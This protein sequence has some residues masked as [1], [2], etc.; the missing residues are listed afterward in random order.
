MRNMA[1][2]AYHMAHSCESY[3]LRMFA[4]LGGSAHEWPSGRALGTINGL[5]AD[6]REEFPHFTGASVECS[7]RGANQ[8]VVRMERFDLQKGLR[9]RNSPTCTLSQNGYG[10]CRFAILV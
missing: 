10:A 6:V 9:D 4:R 8:T 5:F 2:R 7:R 3:C 1:K